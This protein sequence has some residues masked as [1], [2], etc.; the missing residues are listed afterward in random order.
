M[1]FYFILLFFSFIGGAKAEPNIKFHNDVRINAHTFLIEVALGSREL[2]KEIKDKK[3]TIEAV[4]AYSAIR[5]GSYF[6]N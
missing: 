4:N 5:A 6:V 2:P 1:H 3:E